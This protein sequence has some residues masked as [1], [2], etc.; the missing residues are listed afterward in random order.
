MNLF[1]L[2][3]SQFHTHI[4]FPFFLRWPS[5]WGHVTSARAVNHFR[6]PDFERISV[7]ETKKLSLFLF[8]VSL[9]YLIKWPS[10]SGNLPVFFYRLGFHSLPRRPEG[11]QRVTPIRHL[12]HAYFVSLVW[13]LPA[14]HTFHF[15]SWTCRLSC[16]VTG[17]NRINISSVGP[18]KVCFAPRRLL[19]SK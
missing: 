7:W 5:H 17:S 3:K 1:S 9:V 13:W 11:D 10:V 12:L 14:C 8:P 18:I 6:L 16:F 4:P 2:P 15:L 19:R